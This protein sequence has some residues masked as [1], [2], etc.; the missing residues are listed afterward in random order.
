MIAVAPIDEKCIFVGDLGNLGVQ[1]DSYDEEKDF[2]V[3]VASAVYGNQPTFCAGASFYGYTT[4]LNKN[5]V[6]NSLT[7]HAT[8][9][10]SSVSTASPDPSFSPAETTTEAVQFLNG[11]TSTLSAVYNC[12]VFFTAQQDL[13]GSD[14][15]TIDD[16]L[17]KRLVVVGYNG[18]DAKSLVSS[19]STVGSSISVPYTFTDDD[20]SRVVNA[21]EN[22]FR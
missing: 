14:V 21:V 4:L 16:T 19:S 12:L 7:C 11:A 9:F 8:D 15:P 6:K 22:G 1:T 5:T 17:Y 10:A 20:V 13:A 18:T 3:R 2:I